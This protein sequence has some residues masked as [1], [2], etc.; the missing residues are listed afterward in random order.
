MLAN[1]VELNLSQL[2][3]HSDACNA[4]LAQRHNCEPTLTVTV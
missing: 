3:C 4:M 2:Q 1:N